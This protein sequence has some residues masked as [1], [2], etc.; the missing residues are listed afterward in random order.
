MDLISPL[1]V[2]LAI[3]LQ[4]SEI[5][6][7]ICKCHPC[8]VRE[9]MGRRFHCELSVCRAIGLSFGELMPLLREIVD[10]SSNDISR[11]IHVARGSQEDCAKVISA[12]DGEGICVNCRY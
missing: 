8:C 9:L 5:W 1:V 2:C 11:S 4:T 3:W 7:S 6:F 12:L 10:A